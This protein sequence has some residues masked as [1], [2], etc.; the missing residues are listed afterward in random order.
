MGVM[1]DIGQTH[2]FHQIVSLGVVELAVKIAAISGAGLLDQCAPTGRL[3]RG[4][5]LKAAMVSSV[6]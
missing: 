4:S 1:F 2:Q 3:M 6:M 5:S